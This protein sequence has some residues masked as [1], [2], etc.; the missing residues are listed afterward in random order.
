MNNF[1][2][3]LG[4]G[5]GTLGAS[6]LLNGFSF[7]AL[8]Y[9]TTVLGLGAALAGTLIGASKVWDIFT[10]PMMGM[11]SDRSETRWGRRRPFLL[12]GAA[13]SGLAF[14]GLYSLGTTS[15]S[16]SLPVIT[17]LLI[18]LGTGYT[19]FN[20]PYM[21]M[22]AEMLDDYHERTKLMSY[23]VFFI[24]IGTLV[25]GA[26]G[27]RIVELAGGGAEGYAFMGL[28]V[29]AGIF[30][31][32]AAAF[33]GTAR[34]RFTLR[35]SVRYSLAEQLKLGL[36]N[37]PFAMLLGCKFT[38]LFG[39]ASNTATAVF[40]IRFVMEKENPGAWLLWFGVASMTLQIASI[41]LWLKITRRFEK[42]LTYI[43]S[44]VLF[45]IASLSWLLANPAEPLWFFVL[46]AAVKGFA[47]GGLLLMGQSMLPDTIEYDYRSTGL[48]REGIYS[49]LYSIVE[50]LAF[51]ISPAILG[52]ALA[53][54]GFNSKAPTQTPEAVDGIRHAAAFLPALYFALSLPFLFAYGL[55]EKKLRAM[56][57]PALVKS[58]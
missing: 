18:A 55:T 33:F 32:M 3:Y 47:A 37:R 50:K 35:T 43:L 45:V 57:D 6:L 12:L 40:V 29:G 24:G 27:Q 2:L 16:G 54:F 25:G 42:R 34:A 5:V 53:Y 17:I 10:N 23:R 41:P 56:P 52:F 26:A 38:Q 19:I 36:A 30:V 9:L 44:T 21:A 20:V 46:R 49:G 28:A 48:R 51:A 13:V 58:G 31:F 1:K 15:L 39:L 8:Y 11:L 22:P 7:L 14:A 4:W